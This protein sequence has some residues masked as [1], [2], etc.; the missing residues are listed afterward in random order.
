MLLVVDIGNTESVLGLY[1]G[2]T[3]VTHWRISSRLQ[4]TSDE[5]F[6][7]LKSWC[8]K[9]CL[10][11]KLISGVIISS[12]VPALSAALSK[13]SIEHLKLKPVCINADLDLELKILYEPRSSVGAD[14]ICNAVAG[15]N[16]FGGPLIII[17][18]GTAITLDVVSEEGDYLGGVIS[19]GV[20]AAAFELHHRAA[21]L[22]R[23]DLIFP[24]SVVGTSTE[25]SIRSGI[26]WGTSC[27]IDGLIEKIIEEKQWENTKV[28]ATGGLSSLFN[29]TQKYIHSIEPNLTLEGMRMIYNR[30]KKNIMEV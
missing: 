27:L 6:L 1:K 14:R 9:E 21:K 3:I 4:R 26:M 12:V 2:D 22:P 5:M 13:M 15:F 25:N 8:D 19:L 24:D 23:V 20:Q 17:D 16:K 7:M 18:F 10:D 30:I 29:K 11:V 28:I